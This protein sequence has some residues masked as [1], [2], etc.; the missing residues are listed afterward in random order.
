MT[1]EYDKHTATIGRRQFLAAGS[2]AGAAMIGGSQAEAQPLHAGDIQFDE[3]RDMICVGAGA[4]GL[5]SALF[6]KWNGNDVL[7]LEKARTPGGTTQKSAFW[8]WV[9]N[10]TPLRNAGLTDPRED[11]MRYAARI[12]YPQSYNAD[13][14]KLGLTD[15]QFEMIGA[16]W[17]SGSDAA[18]LLDERGALKYRHLD[19]APDY[20]AELP[21]NKTPKGRVL[22]PLE[23][24]DLGSNGGAAAIASLLRSCA[25]E[26]IEVRTQ[27]RVTTLVFDD[28][29]A[30][31]GVQV[32]TPEGLRVIGARKA[33][34]FASGGYTHNPVMRQNFL[35]VPIFGG[36]AALSN[37]GDFI[38]IAS[39]SG[40]ALGNLNYAWF[41]P[42]PLE[43]A[44]AKDPSIS[45]IFTVTGDSMIFVNKYGHRTLNEKLQYNELAQQFFRWDGAKAEMPDL[46]QI[47]VWDQHAQDNCASSDF[48]GLITPDGGDDR[49]VI[50]GETLEELSAAT[51]ERLAQYAGNTGGISLAE[52]FTANLK[53][54]IERFNGFAAAG[55]DEDFARGERQVELLFTGP[56]GEDANPD[57]PTM[58]PISENG[59]YYAALVVGGTLDTK[60]GPVTN[61]HGQVLDTEG[62]PI[63]GL[64]GCGNCVASPTGRAYWSGGGT[65]GPLLAFSYRASIQAN[66]EPVRQI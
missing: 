29:G 14:P 55:K 3:T 58:H 33:V 65:L 24:N 26:E 2:A 47:M 41:C 49:H 7:V 53:S 16:V 44:V 42:I 25:E 35:S 22:Y 11:F 59:P 36:C 18:D 45:G 8:Y 10:N 19:F 31:V 38:N 64:Y 21:E 34:I 32:E 23:G 56:V 50:K 17:D 57:N 30:V 4:G 46:V 27:N 1:K 48:G 9:P 54:A 62:T 6:G 37:E 13:D 39:S 52:D 40:A 51:E 15:W 20:F 43:K 60:G 63:V 61:S 28:A 66:K 5:T 12:S